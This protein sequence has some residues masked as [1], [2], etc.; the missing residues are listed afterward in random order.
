MER[1]SEQEMNSDEDG[2][3]DIPIRDVDEELRSELEEK[4]TVQNRPILNEL[5][6][7]SNTSRQLRKR[8]IPEHFDTP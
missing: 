7:G 4:T 8:F 1:L 2:R 5:L 3:W 6:D